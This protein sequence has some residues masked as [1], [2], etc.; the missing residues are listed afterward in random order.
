MTKRHITPH[1][2]GRDAR[3]PG[4]RIRQQTL[5]NILA[6]KRARGMSWADMVEEKW[7]GDDTMPKS[8]YVY[9]WYSYKDGKDLEF[10]YPADSERDLHEDGKA[11]TVEVKMSGQWVSRRGTVSW[12]GGNY[13]VT[14]R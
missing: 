1:K 4:G 5:D 14:P 6:D 8:N 2:G 13:T 12:G 3:I 7:Q 10:R 11:V 9:G